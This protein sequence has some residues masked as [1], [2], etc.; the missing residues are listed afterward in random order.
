MKFKRI[1]CG[2][3]FSQASVRAFEAAVEL[4]RSF[5]AELHIIHVIEAYPVVAGWLPVQDA[6]DVSASLEE[7]ANNAMGALLSTAADAFN[8]VPVT[9]EVTRGR[10]FVEILNRARDRKVDLIVLGAEGLTLLE[11]AFFGSTVDRVIRRA[12]CSVLVVRG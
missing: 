7:K 1:L 12:D 8:G 6:D 3:D 11:E 2:V 10:S 4:A 9:T 5:K